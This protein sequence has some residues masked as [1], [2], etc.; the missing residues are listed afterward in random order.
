[1]EYVT[2]KLR[3]VYEKVKIVELL[4]VNHSM[5]KYFRYRREFWRVQIWQVKSRR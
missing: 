4:L 1:M 3:N 5:E 2:K